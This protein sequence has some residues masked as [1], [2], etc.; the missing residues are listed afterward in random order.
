V[1]INNFDNLILVIKMSSQFDDLLSK[2]KESL[3]NDEFKI[4]QAITSIKHSEYKEGFIHDLG[5]VRITDRM[6]DGSYEILVTP[7]KSLD[8]IN[9]LTKLLHVDIKIY[10][11]FKERVLELVDFGV[12]NL[13]TNDDIRLS[14]D[15]NDINTTLESILKI[16]L[17]LSKQLNITK[18]DNILNDFGKCLSF[19]LTKLKIESPNVEDMIWVFIS[20]ENVIGFCVIHLWI[21]DSTTAVSKLFDRK[22]EVKINCNLLIFKVSRKLLSDNSVTKIDNL[23]MNYKILESGLTQVDKLLF[24]ENMKYELQNLLN[25]GS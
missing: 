7:G 23:I 24:I 13:F 25:N 3:R 5:E 9:L 11:K 6:I 17:I 8:E 16:L 2:V 18:L 14:L 21:S 4:K 12:I 1:L 15:V 10:E 22:P 20:N 19:K